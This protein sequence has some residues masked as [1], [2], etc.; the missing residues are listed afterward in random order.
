[1]VLKKL[2]RLDKVRIRS[3]RDIL[4][5]EKL[6]VDTNRLQLQNL[7]YEAD[8][9]KKEVQRCYQFKSHDEEIDLVPIEEFYE[10][11]PSEI[12]RPNKT[13]TDEHAKK[14]ARLD[15]ELLQR[16]ELATLCKELQAEKEKVAQEINSKTERLNS[17][18]PGLQALLKA[19]RPLQESLNLNFEK[20]WDFQRSSRLLPRPL[21]LVYVNISAYAEACDKFLS[22]TIKGDEEDA[23]QQLDENEKD[24]LN[25]PENED[26]ENEEEQ[27]ND[28]E[29]SSK[30]HHHN[31]R[32]SKSAVLE[33]KRE[34]LFKPHPLS[35]TLKLNSKTN[36]SSIDITLQYI[37]VLSIVTVECKLNNL[38]STGVVAG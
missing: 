32:L 24:E 33:K 11:A 26:S 4:H 5:K 37:S 9:L 10:K 18:A 15:W 36:S 35:V 1:M 3:Q 22:V 13:K 34:N 27:D 25:K 19:T 12:S 14:I 16:K 30:G 2:N 17:L 31:R 8:H 21:F 28:Q 29:R 38:E 6:R 20:E 23:K 7:L